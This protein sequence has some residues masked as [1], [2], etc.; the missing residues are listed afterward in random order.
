MRQ[1]SKC[2]MFRGKP[3]YS[4]ELLKNE[5]I[6]EPPV[7]PPAVDFRTGN[8][9]VSTPGPSPIAA[10]ESTS[11]PT[12][13][14]Q[15][16]NVYAELAL[17]LKTAKIQKI[18]RKYNCCI[19]FSSFSKAFSL[20]RHEMLHTGERP[21]TCGV[22]SK[23]F[24]QKTDLVRHE[25]THSDKKEFICSQAEC[26]RAFRTKKNLSSHLIAHVE[27]RPCELALLRVLMLS[28]G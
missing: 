23:S 9:D 28:D 10:I 12:V 20:R 11:P 2:P 16:H 8:F 26:G 5:T 19:C 14:N 13:V 22:C 4:Q 25:T 24:I 15:A 18:K 21:F 3:N 17:A 7:F 6:V 27:E 1:K